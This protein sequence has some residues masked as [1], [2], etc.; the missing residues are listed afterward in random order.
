MTGRT[1]RSVLQSLENIEKLRWHRFGQHLAAQAAGLLA[2]GFDPT[3]FRRMALQIGF[4]L[5]AP[6]GGEAPFDE[7]LQIVGRYL[8]SLSHYARSPL[9]PLRTTVSA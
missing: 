3:R 5:A 2:Q 6:L 4:D 1:S 9:L 8:P 7:V